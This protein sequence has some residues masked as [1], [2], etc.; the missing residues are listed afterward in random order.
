MRTYTQLLN[1]LKIKADSKWLTPSQQDIFRLISD[2][3]QTHKLINIYGKEGSGRT[4][5]AW[6]LQSH[7]SWTHVLDI[8]E[9]PVNCSKI[10]ID[11]YPSDKQAVRK[12]RSE[13]IANNS[14]Q[15]IVITTKPAEDDIPQLELRLTQYDVQFVKSNLYQFLDV[16]IKNEDDSWNLH[17]LILNNI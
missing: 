1:E 3:F 4:F 12:I 11:N 17:E 7:Q 16:Q 8:E 15:A 6:M 9:W 2:H 14:Q 5:L 10:V 13:I